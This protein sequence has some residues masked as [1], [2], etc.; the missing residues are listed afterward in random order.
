MTDEESLDSGIGPGV[1]INK[2][3]GQEFYPLNCVF[4]SKHWE[5]GA[6]PDEINFQLNEKEE[7]NENQEESPKTVIEVEVDTR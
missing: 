6:N 4:L 3:W 5:E 7:F 1:I 2:K